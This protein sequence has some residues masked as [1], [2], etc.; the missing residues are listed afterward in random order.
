LQECLADPS[1][2]SGFI[3]L[4]K[5]QAQQQQQ[6]MQQQQATVLAGGAPPGLMQLSQLAGSDAGCH[7]VTDDLYSQLSMLAVQR[8]S[9]P[10][11]SLGL[12]AAIQQQQQQQ[13]QQFVQLPGISQGTVLQQWQLPMLQNATQLPLQQQQQQLT[14]TWSPDTE[15]SSRW[16]LQ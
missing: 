10:A 13:Q 5:E 1:E 7:N 4:A 9:S 14:G 11:D 16:L 3:T 6:I 12:S 2:V 15:S 8:A